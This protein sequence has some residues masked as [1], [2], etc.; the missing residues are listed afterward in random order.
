[1]KLHLENIGLIQ[2]A[3]IEMQ[4]ITVI[5][6]ENGTGKSTVGKALYSIFNSFYEVQ[7]QIRKERFQSV[8]NVIQIMYDLYSPRNEKIVNIH[9]YSVKLLNNRDKYAESPEKLKKDLKV[10]LDIDPDKSGLKID[11]LRMDDFVGRIVESLK[12]S[13]E[14]ILNSLIARKLDIEFNNQLLNMFA[15]DRGKIVLNVQNENLD[16]EVE[17]ERIYANRM[18]FDL[19]TEA[20]YIDDPFVLDNIDIRLR[21]RQTRRYMD[22]RDQLIRKLFHENKHTSVVDEIVVENRFQNIYSKLQNV[23][24]GSMIWRKNGQMEYQLK[25]TDKSISMKNLS[26]GLKT[27]AILKKLLMNGTIEEN[28]MVILDEPEIHLHPAWQLQFAELI[29]LLS[30]E[31]G[32]NVLLNTH[33]PYFLR[34]IQV[35]SAKYEMADK[36]KYYMSELVD[37]KKAGI[38]DVSDDVDK[39]FEKLAQPLQ[40]L[41]NE[42]CNI[43]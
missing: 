10:M 39:I 5:A 31:F 19:H 4:G 13:D 21:Q 14:A 37:D 35:Y 42:R 28:G 22:H 20:I 8:E 15:E 38:F 32:V 30:K 34:A 3:T 2:D 36:C 17:P 29:V 6:G 7:E 40:V 1:M 25:N 26:A 18:D 12:I 41:E 33:S 11:Q 9:G 24:N 27:F 23:C 16:I 43:D